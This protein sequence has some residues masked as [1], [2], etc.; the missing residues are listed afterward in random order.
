MMRQLTITIE[1]DWKAALRTAG[2]SAKASTYQGEV[3]NFE[4]PG[5]FFG[6]LSEKRWEIVRAL[7]G[8]GELPVRELARQLGRD[9]KRV[10]E[11][12][13]ILAEL[14]LIERTEQGGVVCPFGSVHID[15]YLKAV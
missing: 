1:R 8:Q 2:K 10:H 14:G 15:M 4:S 12:V 3:L 7:Q 9:V 6:Q 11:D 5:Q 13:V